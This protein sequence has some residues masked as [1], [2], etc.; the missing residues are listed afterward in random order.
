MWC[1]VKALADQVLD[2]NAPVQEDVPMKVYALREKFHSGG[3]SIGN[4]PLRHLRLLQHHQQLPQGRR[5]QA[6]ADQ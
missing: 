6:V 2:K 3:V 5:K 1:G 4:A